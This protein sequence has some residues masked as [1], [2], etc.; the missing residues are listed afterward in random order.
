M[1]EIVAYWYLYRLP[2]V[3]SFGSQ[4]ASTLGPKYYKK[5]IC[6]DDAEKSLCSD[7]FPHIC[8]VENRLGV[9][10]NTVLKRILGH[11]DEI[12]EGW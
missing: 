11:R 9:F 3:N 6:N 10:E 12:I 5:I 7:F 4:T 2:T 1:A 8:N